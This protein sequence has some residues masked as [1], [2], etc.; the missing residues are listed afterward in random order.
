MSKTKTKETVTGERKVFYSESLSSLKVK[1][2]KAAYRRKLF[3]IAMNDLIEREAARLTVPSSSSSNSDHE[4]TRGSRHESHVKSPLKKAVYNSVHLGRG[5]VRVKKPNGGID[6]KG[7]AEHKEN[8]AL[9]R[10]DW[11]Y[12]NNTFSCVRSSSSAQNREN[13]ARLELNEQIDAS[14]RDTRSCCLC[15][16]RGEKSEA[17]R[18]LFLEH[19]KWIHV[20]CIIWNAAVNELKVNYNE[21]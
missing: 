14:E 13:P 12:W 17:G 3:K 1:R 6:E 5:A 20:N 21:I 19:G 18:L 10:G 4:I 9:S 2:L 11:S 16:M 15:L 7:A 8:V